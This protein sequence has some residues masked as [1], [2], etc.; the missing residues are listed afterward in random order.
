MCLI[1][2]VWNIF[3]LRCLNCPFSKWLVNTE[4]R[5]IQ[6][7]LVLL[8]RISPIIYWLFYFTRSFRIFADPNGDKLNKKLT[9]SCMV[10]NRIIFAESFLLLMIWIINISHNSSPFSITQKHH[11]NVLNKLIALSTIFIYYYLCI[12]L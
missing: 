3:R 12:F 1:T 2:Y 6:I 9:R 8:K 11:V 5:G 7:P 4:A 10:Q